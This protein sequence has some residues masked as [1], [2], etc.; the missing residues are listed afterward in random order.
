MLLEVDSLLVNT[1]PEQSEPEKLEEVSGV[2]P[3]SPKSKSAQGNGSES[4]SN[5][6]FVNVDEKDGLEDM[7]DPIILE[8]PSEN[9]EEIQEQIPEVKPALNADKDDA[10]EGEEKK[11]S[12]EDLISED[13]AKT[14]PKKE[15]P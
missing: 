4:S 13:L 6:G 11:E 2:K 7:S 9:V 3:P 8:H 12:T 10:G 1:E 5:V 14:V 15:E